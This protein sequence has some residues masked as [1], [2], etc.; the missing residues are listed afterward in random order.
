MLVT[1]IDIFA[2]ISGLF[3]VLITSTADYFGFD[4][5]G[6]NKGIYGFNSLLV[7]LGL[8]IYFS[9]GILLFIILFV[10]ALFT[11]FI[12]VSLQGVI[13][14]YA[15]P[16]L[17]IPFSFSMDSNPGNKENSLPWE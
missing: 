17:S 11:L 8:G 2:G 1:F 16:Y 7:G 14:K 13:G 15:F 6:I 4:K 10:A 5:Q 3:S 12:A 9:P